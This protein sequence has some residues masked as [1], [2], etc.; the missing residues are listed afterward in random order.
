[1]N[2]V[3]LV[4]L[5]VLSL[6]ACLKPPDPLK[7][8]DGRVIESETLKLGRDTYRTYCVQCHGEAGDGAGASSLG[9]RPPPRNFA[10]AQ[11][12]FGGVAAG[13]LPTDEA[14]LRTVTRGLHGTPMQ[15]WDLPQGERLAVVQ[16]LKT[17]SPRWTQERPG[18][19]IEPEGADPWSGREAAARAKG[20]AVYHVMAKDHAGCSGCHPA[21]VTREELAALTEQVTAHRP[22]AFAKELHRGKLRDTGY[23]VKAQATDFLLQKAKTIWP[24]RAGYS[25]ADQR[26][27]LYRVIAAGVGGT[28][29]PQWKGALP[30]ENLWALTYYV[31]SLIEL[32]DSD[33][34]LRLRQELS[35]DDAGD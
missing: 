17:F 34:A 11:F 24:Q 35:L 23:G 2:R 19:P 12:K 9:Q 22:M 3:A 30:E 5:L 20:R 28:A 16:Y 4:L 33:A 10:E 7:L 21:Y 29:M 14:L 27:D 25:P 31:Q 18:V 15:G 8:A 26:L 1:M 32:R 13:E 6:G